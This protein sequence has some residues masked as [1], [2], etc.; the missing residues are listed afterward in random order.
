VAFSQ[1]ER[2]LNGD[3]RARR[4]EAWIASKLLSPWNARKTAENRNI[5]PPS[6]SV[7]KRARFI[8]P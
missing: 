6:G 4:S 3:D 2:G 7:M 5:G 8:T 1:R